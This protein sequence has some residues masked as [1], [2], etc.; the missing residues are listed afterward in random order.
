[1]APHQG[2]H[3]ASSKASAKEFDY[4]NAKMAE[5]LAKVHKM[6]MFFD[7]FDVWYVP[8]LDNHDVDHQALIA[9]SRAPI[10]PDVIIDKL[11][12]PLLKSI[13]SSREA[14]R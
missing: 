1:V 5:Y 11:S 7:G 9:S 6:E 2:R 3:I 12:K 8:R 4:N 14:I 13:E 10:P